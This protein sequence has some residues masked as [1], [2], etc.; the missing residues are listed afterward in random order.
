MTEREAL[1]RAIAAEQQVIYGYGVAG[2]HLTGAARRLALA[3]LDVHRVRRDTLI[4]LLRGAGGRPPGQ[5]PAY[6]LPFTVSSPAAARSLCALLEDGG[7][8]AAWDLVTA[9]ASRSAVRTLAVGWLTDAATRAAGWRGSA[10]SVPA[11]PGQP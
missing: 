3:A 9:A 10:A 5:A 1:A 11:L 4:Q 2:A 8:G 6:A 7:A